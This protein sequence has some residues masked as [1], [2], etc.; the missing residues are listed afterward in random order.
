MLKCQDDLLNISM[1][2]WFYYFFIAFIAAIALLLIVSVFPIPGNYKALVVLSGSMEPMIKVGSVVIVKPS[3]D[4]KVGDIITF[5]KGSKTP[6]THRIA[7]I[8]QEESKVLYTVKGDANEDPDLEKVLKENVIGKVFF[9]IPYLGYPLNFA[10]QPIGFLLLVWTPA[11][12]I[13]LEEINNIRAEI[14]KRKTVRL[15]GALKV[16]NLE[17]E[18]KLSRYDKPAVQSNAPITSS[19]LFKTYVQKKRIIQA[20]PRKV[21]MQDIIKTR[22]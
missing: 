3:E 15:E 11:I 5:S 10:K 21:L 1:L 4:Y 19:K 14:K 9:S 2:K 17:K 22:S 6:T 20:K 12:I 18:S 8:E 7:D 13:V 16:E